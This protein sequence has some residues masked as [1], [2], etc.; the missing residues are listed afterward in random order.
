MAVVVGELDV[1]RYD[2]LEKQHYHLRDRAIAHPNFT[3][4][5]E[6]EALHHRM[7]CYLGVGRQ[8]LHSGT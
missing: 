1:S 6:P 7:I 4:R 8:Y 3:T 5:A 2:H